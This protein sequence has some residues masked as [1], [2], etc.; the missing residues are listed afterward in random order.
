MAWQMSYR[1]DAERYAPLQ[2]G[3]LTNISLTNTSG[4]SM[5]VTHV[6]LKFDWMGTYRYVRECNIKVGPG[7]TVDLPDIRFTVGL[8]TSVGSHNFKL[9]I[10]YMLLED[11]NWVTYEDIYVS[12]GDFIEVYRLPPKDFKVF[13]SHSNA[14]SDVNLIRACKD[15]MKA[16]GLTGYFAEEDAR[17][18]IK[19]WDKIAREI[20]QS[21]ALL[22][23]WT[24]DAV[25]S[26]DV[27]EEI[28]ISLG[29][30]KQDKIV[31]V[32][33]KGVEVS[34]SLKS[35]GIEWV[36]YGPPNHMQAISKALQTIME[37]AIQKEVMK[38]VM[39]VRWEQTHKK[40]KHKKVDTAT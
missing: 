37:W 9:G 14:P 13:V 1:L 39:K 40:K 3:I 30:K 2:S 31:P 26:G 34:G 15:A 18:G 27:R 23:L 22:V 7:K 4:K 10:S 21:D 33:E 8:G 25:I 35:R 17:P 38:E 36:D 16:C 11:D 6:L 20:M 28:G 24:N 29:A 5:I 19:L 32:V 12:R